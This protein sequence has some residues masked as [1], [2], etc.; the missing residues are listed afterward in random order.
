MVVP[1][2]SSAQG[3]E[4][5]TRLEQQIVSEHNLARSDPASYAAFLRRL[6]PRYEGRRFVVSDRVVRMTQEGLAAVDEAIRFL[7]SAAAAPQVR[8]SRGMSL[9]ARDLVDD[10]GPKG[11]TGHVG[12]DGSQPWDRV[13]RYGEWEGEIAENV[14]YGFDTGGDV[15]LQLIVDDGVPGRGHRLNIFNPAFQVVGVACGRHAR[16]ETMCVITYA[17]GYVEN[18]GLHSSFSAVS[19]FA[20]GWHAP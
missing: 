9:G 12:T 8:A 7:E 15:V 3:S 5:L 11:S 10:Q 19:S 13:A 14:A 6:K 18:V 2:Q 16:Y 4:Y 20:R 1:A 17:A